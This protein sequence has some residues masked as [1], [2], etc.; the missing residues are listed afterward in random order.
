LKAVFIGIVDKSQTAKALAWSVLSGAEGAFSPGGAGAP[1][2]LGRAYS[3]SDYGIRG[4]K[5]SSFQPKAG[6]SLRSNFH[7]MD[8]FLDSEP[9]L[10]II[11]CGKKKLNAL[12][13]RA[14]GLAAF[15]GMSSQKNSQQ[16]S[17]LERP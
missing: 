8:I 16:D 9:S 7:G 12:Q 4:D 6:G 15:F 14:D 1:A 10:I 3:I 2:L 13:R 11:Q 5:Q 17:S